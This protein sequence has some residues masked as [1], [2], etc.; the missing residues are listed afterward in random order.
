LGRGAAQALKRLKVGPLV[1]GRHKKNIGLQQAISKGK[2]PPERSAGQ[3]ACK[4][5]P[6]G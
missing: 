4:E 2:A 6:A 5:N 3:S 1:G